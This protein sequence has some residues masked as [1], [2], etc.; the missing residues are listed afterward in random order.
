MN[1]IDTNILER[2]AG[3][4]TVT[5]FSSSRSRRIIALACALRK[6]PVPCLQ[7]NPANMIDAVI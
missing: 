2:D 5:H 4:K 1:V 6:P 7:S 3:R